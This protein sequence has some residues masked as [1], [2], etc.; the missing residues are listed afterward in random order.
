M[1]TTNIIYKKCDTEVLHENGLRFLDDGVSPE[2]DFK[3]K[4]IKIIE[5]NRERIIKFENLS[6]SAKEEIEYQLQNELEWELEN[7]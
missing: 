7:E 3:I 2:Q 5:I 4:E 1:I 6:K